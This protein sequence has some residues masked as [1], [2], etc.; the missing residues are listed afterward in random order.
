MTSILTR[1]VLPGDT[2]PLPPTTAPGPE[3][4]SKTILGPGTHLSSQLDEPICIRPGVVQVVGKRVWVEGF[5]KRV[6]CQVFLLVV[7][8]ILSFGVVNE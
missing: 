2:L 7:A 6:S 8:W 5:G 4:V 1:I 3:G